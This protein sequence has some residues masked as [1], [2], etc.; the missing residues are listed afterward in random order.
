MLDYQGAQA[1]ALVAHPLPGGM[2]DVRRL[3]SVARTDQHRALISLMGMVGCRVSEALDC[4]PSWFDLGQSIVEI[5][6]KGDKSRIVPVSSQAMEYVLVPLTR[7]FVAGDVR[8]IN[9]ADRT[10]RKV[11][12][13]LGKKAKL[14]RAISS[15][16]L[17]ATFATSL[18][19]R[20]KDPRLVQ[21]LLG[22][23]SIVTTQGYIGVYLE[24]AR[25]AVEGL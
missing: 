2:T 4:R 12:T 14:A 8:I 17:R 10:A 11:V 23:A 22:H 18:Y 9:I 25:K 1:A 20:T 6:G 16:D 19:D 13:S 15:H 21:E 7:A 24:N 3:I 5:R